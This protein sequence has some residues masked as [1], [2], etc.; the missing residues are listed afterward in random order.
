MNVIQQEA[1]AKAVGL[2]K[3]QLANSLIEQEAIAKLSDFEGNTARERYQKAVD[4]LGVEEARRRLGNDILA[5][6][7]DSQSVQEKFTA[8]VERLKEIFIDLSAELL[9]IVSSIANMVVGVAKLVTN[10]AHLLNF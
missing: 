8:S 4:A 5:D 7:M 6:Q 1:M 10:L 3:D 2:T 9:P